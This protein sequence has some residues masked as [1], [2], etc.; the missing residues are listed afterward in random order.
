MIKVFQLS[1]FFYQF[2]VLSVDGPET[3]SALPSQRPDTP[4]VRYPGI[5]PSVTDIQ[6]SI[7]QLQISRFRF[8]NYMS[9][10]IDSSA[11]DPGGID[12]SVADIQVSISA[13][14]IQVSI[15]KLHMSKYLFIS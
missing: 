12:F 5:N 11:A 8:I 3:V 9:P 13:A 7:Y 1:T 15:H 14:D 4:T 10:G 6:V 2:E